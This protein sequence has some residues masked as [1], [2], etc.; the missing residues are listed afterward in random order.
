M[1]SELRAQGEKTPQFC[2][3]AHSKTAETIQKLYEEVYQPK[4]ASDFWYQW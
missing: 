1:L 3:I 2:F 4:L